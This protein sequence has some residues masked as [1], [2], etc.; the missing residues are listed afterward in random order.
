M[1]AVW[2]GHYRIATKLGHP[3]KQSEN[4]AESL[5]G[6]DKKIFATV[7]TKEEDCQRTL[8]V[9]EERHDKKLQ[10][11]SEKMELLL[12]EFMKNKDTQAHHEEVLSQ[13]IRKKEEQMSLLLAQV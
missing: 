5:W 10:E 3:Y 7:A 11:Y 8:R 6:G 2:R 13:K 9:H 4:I 12:N 1:E